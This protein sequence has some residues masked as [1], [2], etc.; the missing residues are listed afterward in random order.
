MTR[1]ITMPTHHD[2]Q[3]ARDDGDDE[4][5]GIG[6]RDVTGVAAEHEHR[7]MREVEHAERAVDDGQP[8]LISASRAPSAS[9]LKSCETKLGQL[10]MTRNRRACLR[11]MR[12]Q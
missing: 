1:S 10:I 4:R 8:E 7:A 12:Y 5:V 11:I 2:K 9:P 6:V 3:R